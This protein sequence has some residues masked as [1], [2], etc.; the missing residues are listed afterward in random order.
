MLE[1]WPLSE[2]VLFL[3]NKHLHPRDDAYQHALE[4]I[5]T[6][7]REPPVQTLVFLRWRLRRLQNHQIFSTF[8]RQKAG[9]RRIGD[10]TNPPRP[11][12]A[13][14]NSDERAG[15]MWREKPPIKAA[16]ALTD[17]L[18]PGL[19]P[20]MTWVS[21][22]RGRGSFNGSQRSEEKLGLA[23]CRLLTWTSDR[24]EQFS[25][26]STISGVSEHREQNIVKGR[27]VAACLHG[28][29]GLHLGLKIP[30]AMEA[31]HHNY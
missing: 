9:E 1:S 22:V 12:W 24:E 21:S 20:R 16:G 3:W 13:I 30:H 25:W 28:G 8:R 15:A 23:H 10:A 29:H 18:G 31:V 6:P 17:W 14:T 7:Q 27:P 5:M 11:C 19:K 26:S 2:L 4:S